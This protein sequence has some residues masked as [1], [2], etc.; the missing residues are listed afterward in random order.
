MGSEDLGYISEVPMHEDFRKDSNESKKHAV[1]M[2]KQS[3]GGG[4]IMPACKSRKECG[5]HEKSLLHAEK[6][7]T[8]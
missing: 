6:G 5:K 1:D 3:R 4:I 2:S 8:I 7:T